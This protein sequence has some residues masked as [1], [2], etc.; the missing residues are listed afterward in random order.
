[1]LRNV[2]AS[3]APVI[4]ALFIGGAATICADE[5]RRQ[6]E[7]RRE[8]HADGQRGDRDRQRV[9]QRGLASGH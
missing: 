1:M 7:P 6:L 2:C 3:I 9:N 8:H 4:G 5:A